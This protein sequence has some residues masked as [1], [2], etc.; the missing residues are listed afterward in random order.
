MDGKILDREVWGTNLRRGNLGGVN[1]EGGNLGGGSSD[2]YFERWIFR[3]GKFGMR[4]IRKGGIWE[5]KIRVG[6]SGGGYWEMGQSPSM[7]LRTTR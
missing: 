4:E 3:R 5:G 7:H 6:G 2:R 1:L